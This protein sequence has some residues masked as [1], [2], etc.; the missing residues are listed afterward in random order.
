VFVNFV[1]LLF[2]LPAGKDLGGA[3]K[4]EFVARMPIPL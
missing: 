3:V 4:V 2:V 1:L